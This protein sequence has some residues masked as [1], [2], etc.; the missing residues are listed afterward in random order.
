MKV[1]CAERKSLRPKFARISALDFNILGSVGIP[2]PFAIRSFLEK[3]AAIAD[4]AETAAGLS[5][6]A[7]SILAWSSAARSGPINVSAKFKISFPPGTPMSNDGVM[8]A[9]RLIS[10]FVARPLSR[11]NRAWPVV[12]KKHS[13]SAETLPATISA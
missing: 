9:S 4:A 12:Q 3:F 1:F 11:R 6:F 2:Q 7:S 5:I 13:L 8:R 10:R